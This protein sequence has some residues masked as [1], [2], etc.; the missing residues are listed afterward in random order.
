MLIIPTFTFLTDPVCWPQK[1]NSPLT[2]HV[3]IRKACENCQK[4]NIDF[5]LTANK[6]SSSSHCLPQFGTCFLY[7]S[8]FQVIPFASL[9]LEPANPTIV[10]MIST[11]NTSE[12]LC[13]S[14]VLSLRWLKISEILFLPLFLTPLQS[15]QCKTVTGIPKGHSSEYA[16]LLSALQWPYIAQSKSSWS[17]VANKYT[18]LPGSFPPNNSKPL[19]LFSFSSQDSLALLRTCL[20]PQTKW[21]LPLLFSLPKSTFLQFI[22]IS[23]SLTIYHSVTL[24]SLFKCLQLPV[25]CHSICLPLIII[26][27]FP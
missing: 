8:N 11:L 22:C 3:D 1:S 17:F 18:H 20:A 21:P 26:N 19:T 5:P 14:H 24:T 12:H 9:F 27:F 2:A 16:I 7:S 6:V 4:P 23:H 25:C 13:P 15:I 10:I